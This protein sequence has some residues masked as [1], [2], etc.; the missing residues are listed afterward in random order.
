MA[1]G[2]KL[3]EVRKQSGM[4]Q[5]TF[6]EQLHVSRQA[7]SRW[8]SGRGY[9]EIEKILYI[10]HRYHTTLDV[11]FA[12]ELPPSRRKRPRSSS[13]SPASRSSVP[14]LTFSAIFPPMTSSS[15]AR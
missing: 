10:C 5:E 6:A 2:E 9:P 1:F 15:A 14:L 4:T 12:D 7:V 13:P 11:L 3:Q 8:E